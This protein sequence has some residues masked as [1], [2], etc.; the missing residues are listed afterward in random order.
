[1]QTLVEQSF[2]RVNLSGADLGGANIEW[3]DLDNTDITVAQNWR[4]A[5]GINTILT[6]KLSQKLQQQNQ[7]IEQL[8][9]ELEAAKAA[10]QA[11]GKN[12]E[13]IKRLSNELKQKQN[14]HTETEKQL[15]QL[16]EE[17]ERYRLELE[18]KNQIL[19]NQIDEA[20]T[21]LADT[22]KNSAD[23]QIKKTRM[24]SCYLR[25]CRR[26]IN[27]GRWFFNCLLFI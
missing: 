4:Y 27:F 14:E 24:G 7:E 20:Q 12:T 17:N 26:I 16:Q 22:F 21:A 3:T 23:K 15:H 19:S 1:M 5:I 2:F 8:K 6:D 11:D 10:E 9:V 18:N 13:E 25:L